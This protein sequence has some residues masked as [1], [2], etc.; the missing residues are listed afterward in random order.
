MAARVS[1]Y[2][3]THE[4]LFPAYAACETL[5]EWEVA[6]QTYPAAIDGGSPV[7]YAMRVCAGNQDVLSDT[8]ICKAVNAPPDE[9]LVLRAS[10]Q[11]GLLGAPLPDGARLLERTRGNPAEYIDP[12]ETYSIEATA[13]DIDLFFK[14]EMVNAGWFISHSGGPII[15][16]E[17]EKDD[18]I[19]QV[20]IR[21]NRF[22]LLGS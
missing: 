1:E 11:T 15:D 5:D 20:Y 14:H 18:Y 3:D 7:E 13:N 19:L 6:H 10:G 2:A 16:I 21:D 12:T 4:D 22:T 17:F 8:P 9:P